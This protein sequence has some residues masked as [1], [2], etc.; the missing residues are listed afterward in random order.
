MIFFR[1]SNA[2]KQTGFEDTLKKLGLNTGPGSNGVLP[3][4]KASTRVLRQTESAECLKVLNDWKAF[5]ASGDKAVQ[6]KNN[7]KIQP[8][9]IRG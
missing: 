7:A 3:S 4:K 2:L 5:N 1:L 8:D 9:A 6:S